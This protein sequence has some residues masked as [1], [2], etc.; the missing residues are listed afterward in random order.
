MDSVALVQ[1]EK[2]LHHEYNQVLFQEMLHWHQKSRERWVKLG[3]KNTSFFHAQTIIR[4]KR[5]KIHGLQLPNGIWC[6]DEGILQE[7]AFN[8]FRPLFC[9]NNHDISTQF[10]V[11]NV[12]SLTEEAKAILMQPVSKYEVFKALNFM[13][14]FKV[15]GPDG[16]QPIFFKQYWHVVG[17]DIW[18]LVKDTFLLGSFDPSISETL[19]V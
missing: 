9:S 15:P 5:N 2:N 16:F 18:K 6:C 3:D 17:D 10:M 14:P 8:F 12:P 7:E 11:P 1:L 19:I 13:K 4:R